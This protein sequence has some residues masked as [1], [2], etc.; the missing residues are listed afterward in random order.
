MRTRYFLDGMIILVLVLIVTV[1]LL[2]IRESY[3]LRDTL[4]SGIDG[5]GVGIYFLCFE[6]D[7]VPTADLASYSNSFLRI[8][9]GLLVLGII[10]SIIVLYFRHHTTKISQS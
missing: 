9:T 1:G 3:V 5:D 7:R 10:C 8:G 2:M 6:W 4:Q